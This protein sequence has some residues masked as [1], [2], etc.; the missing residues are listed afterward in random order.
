MS[1]TTTTRL[2]THN[3]VFYP[4]QTFDVLLLLTVPE[5]V[6]DVF[7]VCHALHKLLAEAGSVERL[8]ASAVVHLWKL[9]L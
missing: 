3:C 2:Q 1:D 7:R 8:E 4:N 9:R 5:K 6:N